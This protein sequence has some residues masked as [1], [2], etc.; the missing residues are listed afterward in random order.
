MKVKL[1]VA[2]ALLP[3]AAFAGPAIKAEDIIEAQSPTLVCQSAE[4]LIAAWQAASN[5]EQTRVAAF[6]DKKRCVF[7]DPGDRLRVLSTRL[8]P[9]LEVVPLSTKSAE[10]G[11][12]TA[13]GAYKKV[14]K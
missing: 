11:L 14:N 4:D 3:S 12:F 7:A 10:N 9:A 2:L 1:A 6:L 8:A 5:G 13:S